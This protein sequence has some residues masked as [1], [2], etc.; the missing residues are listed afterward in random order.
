LTRQTR[1]HT[2]KQ[3]QVK[4]IILAEL[5]STQDNANLHQDG[6]NPILT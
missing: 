2:D 4:K 1:R 3:T 6:C 5:K